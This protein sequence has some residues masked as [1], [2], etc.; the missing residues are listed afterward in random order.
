[1][2]KGINRQIIEINDTSSTYYEKAWLMVRPEYANLH[3]SLLEKEA[4]KLLKDM[5]APSSM[6]TKRNL[7]AFIPRFILFA[8]IGAGIT[9]LTQSLFS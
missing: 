6:K 7:R 8:V 1:M 4:K 3:Q 2:I 5:D 9:L